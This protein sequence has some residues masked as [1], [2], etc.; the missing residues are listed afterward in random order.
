[1]LYEVITGLYVAGQDSGQRFISPDQSRLDLNPD[2]DIPS[3]S[4]KSPNHIELLTFDD[5]HLQIIG[6]R[7]HA[8]GLAM[9]QFIGL[10]HG[11]FL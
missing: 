5:F 1:M 4:I 7:P 2:A 6:I 8:D 11:S 10:F 3:G 9:K